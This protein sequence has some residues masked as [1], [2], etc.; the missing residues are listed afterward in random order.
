MSSIICKE[1]EG[2]E[3]YEREIDVLL[4]ELKENLKKEMIR[5]LTEN[6]ILDF[7]FTLPTGQTVKVQAKFAKLR[8]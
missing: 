8:A 5:E 1:V 2:K 6:Y 3:F 4:R 7:T